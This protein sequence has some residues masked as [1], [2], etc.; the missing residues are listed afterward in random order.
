MPRDWHALLENFSSV[1]RMVHLAARWDAF[2]VER[3][4][5]EYLRDMRAA[6]NDELSIQA[7]NVGCGDKVGQMREGS[8]A[9]P[10]LRDRAEIHAESV[11]N[12]YNYDLAL[13]IQHIKA[14]TPRANRHTYASRLSGWNERRNDW[15]VPQISNMLAGDARQFAQQDFVEQ[16]RLRDGTARLEPR[17]AVCPICQG[18]I[19]RGNVPIYVAMAN[20]PPYHV[21]CPH[22]WQLAY[23]RLPEDL[24][25]T[26]WMGE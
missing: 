14:E 3:Q 15:K 6:Y 23:R 9:L 12:T 5:G 24:C 22:Y 1:M 8:P 19:N 20:P 10:Q 17:T 11:V 21:N 2:D 4:R 7:R 25:A 13:A 18:W 26:L 16:N